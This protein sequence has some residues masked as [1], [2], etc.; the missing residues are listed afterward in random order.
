MKTLALLLFLAG[1]S[2]VLADT[3]V[4]ENGSFSDGITSWEGDV[5]TAGGSSDDSNSTSGVVVGLRSSDWTKISQVFDGKSG[6]YLLT[7]TYTTTPGM[8]ISNRAEDYQNTTLKMGLN[9]MAPINTQTGDWVLMVVD[10]GS[11]RSEYWQ[12]TP[13]INGTGVQTIK[14]QV[15]L[16]SGDDHKKGFYLGFPPGSG[17]INLQSI[18]LVP[19]GA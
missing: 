6:D 14:T 2:V 5:H 9:G 8:T 18:T 17:T 13:T 1:G 10:S 16:K 15:S 4:L 11:A 3:D 19:N 12:I 7:I